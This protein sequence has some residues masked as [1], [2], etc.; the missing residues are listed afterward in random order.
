[1]SDTFILYA[2]I[3][4]TCLATAFIVISAFL[5]HS[6]PAG[7]PSGPDEAEL[8]RREYETMLRHRRRE[9]NRREFEE[10]NIL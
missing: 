8:Q 3:V 1:M 6:S 2:V 9:K 5:G 4:F 7:L 10:N